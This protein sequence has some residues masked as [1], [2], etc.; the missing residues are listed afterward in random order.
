MKIINVETSEIINSQ[1]FYSTIPYVDAW[2]TGLDGITPID[3]A[4]IALQ[5]QNK[6]IPNSNPNTEELL[7]KAVKKTNEKMIKYIIK[8]YE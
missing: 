2:T 6:S 1:T 8:F 4:I 3:L 7:Q 5:Q